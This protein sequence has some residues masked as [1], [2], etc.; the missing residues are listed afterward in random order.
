MC[1]R[2]KRRVKEKPCKMES[3]DDC[4]SDSML[5]TF[6]EV[7][8]AVRRGVE[9]WPF[10]SVLHISFSLLLSPL[11]QATSIWQTLPLIRAQSPD[12]GLPR[13]AERGSAGSVLLQEI[14][15]VLK[16]GV[17]RSG[18][19]S[20]K[21]CLRWASDTLPRPWRAQTRC[22]FGGPLIKMIVVRPS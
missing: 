12:G 1:V 19:C 2:G 10:P 9:S 15:E 16:Q 7:A 22:C 5:N 6:P 18:Y 4:H 13:R 14:G 17:V 20:S 21:M 8:S 3:S 11:S